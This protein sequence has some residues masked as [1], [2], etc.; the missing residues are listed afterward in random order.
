MAEVT[1]REVAREA[2][3]SVSTVSR[4]LNDRPFVRSEVRERVMLVTRELGYRPDVA[5]RSMRTGTTGVVALVVSDIS[6][7]S[8]PLRNRP[9]RRSALVVTL[10][11][12]NSSND[13]AHEEELM[14]A[15]RQRRLDGLVI[16]VADEEAAGPGSASSG[17]R[18][19][20][21]WIA[22]FV[23]TCRLRPFRPCH[24]PGRGG[25]TPRIARSRTDRTDRGDNGPTWEPCPPLDVPAGGAASRPRLG[26]RAVSGRRAHHRRRISRRHRDPRD[27][28]A[29]DCDHR[30]KQ[31][32]LR[33]D[34]RRAA[35]PERLHSARPLRRGLRGHGAHGISQSAPRRRAA[36]PRGARARGVRA[37]V[38]QA[39]EPAPENAAGRAADHIRT[40]WQQRSSVATRA[41]EGPAVSWEIAHPSPEQETPPHPGRE[42]GAAFESAPRAAALG[43]TVAPVA[44]VPQLTLT[45][46]V[47][48]GEL[49]LFRADFRSTLEAVVVCAAGRALSAHPEVNVTVV[50]RVGRPALVPATSSWVQLLVLCDDRLRGKPTRRGTPVH[51]RGDA[52]AAAGR[53]LR[54]GVRRSRP[55]RQRC[56]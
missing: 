47:E 27:A 20:S 44:P 36:Q 32:A 39:R 3:V 21:S 33:R 14:A 28:A 51:R 46:A 5:A 30:R 9:T 22:R 56:R 13:P 11:V 15:L 53:E 42:T 6:N 25:R 1:L 55:N 34:V 10:M 17:F 4:V 38:G 45:T 12:A 49:L 19:S 35:R 7:S 41:R 8:Q 50:E 31:P 2:G 29:A 16:A 48:A 37:S 54:G 18:P 23:R 24:R 26:R 43:P 40:A 52:A